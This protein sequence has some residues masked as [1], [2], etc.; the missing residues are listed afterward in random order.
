MV[1]IYTPIGRVGT[2]N[3]AGVEHMTSQSQVR[4]RRAYTSLTH[5][6]EVRL[7]SA[8]QFWRLIDMSF[9]RAGSAEL[10]RSIE[11][12]INQRVEPPRP[13]QP[14]YPA[15]PPHRAPLTSLHVSSW[16]WHTSTYPIFNSQMEKLFTSLN[17]FHLKMLIGTKYPNWNYPLSSQKIKRNTGDWIYKIYYWFLLINSLF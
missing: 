1:F 16:P 12:P 13:L 11:P 6:W 5:S 14:F 7:L 3:T 17:F 2:G 4:T 9:G 10:R 15:P 8:V